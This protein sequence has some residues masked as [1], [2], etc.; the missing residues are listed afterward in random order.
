MLLLAAVLDPI[1]ATISAASIAAAQVLA[2]ANIDSPGTELNARAGVSNGALVLCTQNVVG[3]NAWTVYA[4][5]SS[6]SASV[7]SPYIVAASGSGQWIAVAGKYVNSALNIGA[8]TTASSG[9]TGALIVGGGVGIA[10]S[11][12]CDGGRLVVGP[13][14][15]AVTISGTT[16]TSA[17]FQVSG[18]GVT[19]SSFANLR[20]SNNALSA[21]IVFAK[22]RGAAVGTHAVVANNDVVGLLVGNG[23]DGTAFREAAHIQFAVD[24]A[25]ISSSSMP[26]RIVFLTTPSG[27]VTPAEVLRL[28]NAKLA[29]FAGAISVAGAATL[30]TASTGLTIAITTGTSLVVSST[31]AACAT[32]AGGITV[33]GALTAGASGITTGITATGGTNGGILVTSDAGTTN[34]PNTMVLRHITSG[35]PAANFGTTMSL[36]GQT[37]TSTRE[38]GAWTCGWVDATDATRMANMLFYVRDSGGSRTL[39]SGEATGTAAKIGFFGATN[40]VKYA[41]TGT[42]AGFTAGAS[43]AVLN[44]STF[45]GNTGATAYTVGDLVRCLKQYGLLTS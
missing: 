19:Q 32:F 25:T 33:S 38:M 44:D 21:S 39:F 17:F 35:T 27:S 6:S 14:S 31:A 16:T 13:T 7:N 34:K 18:T 30:T 45:T 8:T 4:F 5:D 40:V 1:F 20:W 11:V 36:E 43:T 24:G 2:V 3:A 42:T 37:T 26:G 12:F 15:Q 29:T 10:G 9:T 23:S 28:D 22:S 41:T